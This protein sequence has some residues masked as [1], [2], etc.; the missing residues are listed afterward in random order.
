[1]KRL[2]TT[3]VM[4]YRVLFFFNNTWSSIRSNRVFVVWLPFAT[5]TSVLLFLNC[6][7]P[8][9]HTHTHTH[10]FTLLDQYCLAYDNYTYGWKGFIFEINRHDWTFHL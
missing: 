4:K 2:P 1:M 7:C 9:T 5:S 6:K 3:A 8:H 10:T